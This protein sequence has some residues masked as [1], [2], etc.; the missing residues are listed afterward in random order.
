MSHV[1]TLHERMLR[2]LTPEQGL[3]VE[4]LRQAVW[5]AKHPVHV[6]VPCVG[7]WQWTQNQAFADARRWFLEQRAEVDTWLDLLGLPDITY[8]RLLAEAGLAVPDAAA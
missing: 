4:V 7:S 1:A 6:H 3:A 5:D 8:A 2:E